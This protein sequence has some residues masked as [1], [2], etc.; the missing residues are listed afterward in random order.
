[1]N[2]TAKYRP[3]K[4]SQVV[5]QDAVVSSLRGSLED[6][7]NP[8]ILLCGPHGV[9]KTTLAWLIALY[10]NCT[11]RTDGEICG[12]CDSCKQTIKA[13]RYGGDTTS[14]VE[15]QVSERGIDAIR[16]LEQQ[17]KYRSPHKYRFFI[18]DEAHNLTRQAFDAALR[19]FEKPH[20]Q[21]RFILCTTNPEVLPTTIRS[22][23]LIYYLKTVKP[24]VLAK[25]LLLPVAKKEGIAIP[26][27]ATLQIARA[28]DGHP[29]DALN[30]LSQ[31]ASAGKTG[32]DLVKALPAIIKQS[33]ATKTYVAV[34]HYVASVL[35]GKFG[36]AIAYST[37]VT[38]HDYFIGQIIVVLEQL[39]LYLISP[40][41]MDE[42]KKF[43]LK[44]V[45]LPDRKSGNITTKASIIAEML[46]L[47][48]R[49]Q[50]RIK[51]YYTNNKVILEVLA[52][53][54][55]NLAKDL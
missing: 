45:P 53:K 10:A 7:I 5:G 37:E 38:A 44:N 52:V 36:K 20:S 26:P 35:S 22:R 21:A 47:C 48:T 54:L 18:I 31:V 43:M 51:T 11:N 14:V 23:A 28:V 1:M 55:A 25:K 13:I 8:T 46:D 29:R 41:L 33:D 6:E 19:L 32:E 15:K 49:E 9:G 24:E 2:F 12:K 27:K 17:A 39:L 4:F 3:I 16:A 30:L 50:E 34:Q 42:T 40:N